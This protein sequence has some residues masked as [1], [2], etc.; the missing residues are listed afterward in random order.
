MVTPEQAAERIGRLY[1]RKHSEWAVAGAAE[2][3]VDIPLHPPTQEQVLAETKA[4]ADWT[5]LWKQTERRL[6]DGGQVVWETRQWANAG[7][8][9]MPVRLVLAEPDDAA[10]FIRRRGHWQAAESRTT[11]LAGLLGAH[12]AAPGAALVEPVQEALRR[13]AKRI[14]DLDHAEYLRLRAALVWLL[15]NPQPE[16]YPRQMPIRGVDSK[17]LEKHSSLVE[18]LIAS[19][20]GSASLGLLKPPGLVR[21]RFLDPALAP[22]GLT[23]LSAPVQ[24]LNQLAGQLWEL[25]AVI[26]VENLQTLLALPQADGVAAIHSSGYAAKS[27][28]SIEWLRQSPLLYWGDLDVD[29]FQ[30]LAMIRQA[31]P[32]TTSVLMDR[33]TLKEHLDLSGPDRKDAPRTVPEHLTGVERDACAA[34]A[35][36]GG[37]RLEQER[38]P[39]EYALERLNQALPGGSGLS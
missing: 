27:L 3:V 9:R 16:I 18:P 25:R 20:S 13:R 4:A 24:E 15:Q 23:G 2:P 31:L 11:E 26:V 21:M 30:I 19:A 12:G 17:W 22:G 36:Y 37:V 38:I 1:E 7:S 28:S 33:A 29:G 14:A 35:D 34:L 6:G 8:Q 39:W 5:A 32:Q 10:A